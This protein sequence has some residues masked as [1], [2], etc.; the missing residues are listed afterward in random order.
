MR[1]DTGFTITA[2]QAAG[3]TATLD[4]HAVETRLVAELRAP[5]PLPARVRRLWAVGC[6]LRGH[7]SDDE[8][9]GVLIASA[10]RS[11]LIAALG[12]HGRSDIEHVIAWALRGHDPF[13]V[14]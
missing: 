7:A 3:I 2:I 6:A 1:D 9:R 14:G 8:A 11:G 4:L 13:G 5:T 10:R 12:K